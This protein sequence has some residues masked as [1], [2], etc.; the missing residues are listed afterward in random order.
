MIGGSAV[1]VLLIVAAGWAGW[2]AYELR[3]ELTEANSA[4][5][6]LRAAV[7]AGDDPAIQRA[8]D[9]LRE[10]GE[11]ASEISGGITWSALAHVPVYGDDARGIKV[12]SDVLADLTGDDLEPLIAASERI[13]T[14]LP[15]GGRV[16]ID[17]IVELQGPLADGHDALSRAYDDL[18]AQ[19]SSGFSGALRV[20]YDE[21]TAEI[22]R[23][24][25]ALAA[26]DTA[27]QVLPDMLG[28]TVDKRYLLVFQNN[29]EARS[30]GGLPGAVALLAASDGRLSLGRQVAGQ[31]FGTIRTPVLPLTAAET[32]IYGRL[33]GTD[34]RDAN[35][36]PDFPRAA[37]LWQARWEQVYDG[38]PVDGVLAVDPVA[39]SYL[40]GATGPVTVGGVT[41]TAENAVEELLSKTYARFPDPDDQDAWFR[42]VASAVFTAVTAGGGSGSDL[43]RALARGGSESRILVHSFDDVDQEE[44]AGT[45]I[46]G[47]L[48]DADGTA[49]QLGLYLNDFTQSKMSYY[50]DYDVDVSSTGCQDGVE[51]LT[52]SATFAST[53][54]ARG[55][56]LTDYV[57]GGY[58]GLGLLR[59]SQVVAVRL[60]GPLG[61][62]ITGL[63]GDGA[64]VDDF[65]V[66]QQD[67]RPVV[68]TFLP[69][70]PGEQAS[71]E[72]QVE[73]GSGQRG[74]PQVRLTPGARS[75][76]DVVSIGPASC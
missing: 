59:G 50:L 69:L 29:A 23:A 34:F 71:I 73:A 61:G 3:G 2:R 72:W 75:G 58:D 36:T 54:P 65:E 14:L 45:R 26:A 74:A 44:L 20:K 16:P 19:S 64:S 6:E 13:D 68:T 66:V 40:L 37:A 53:A 12:A 39:L 48:S 24:E 7:D 38:E 42:Q 32:Q 47:E 9:R 33:L 27:A 67:G 56:G 22:G 8:V 25:R 76:D 15:V 49:P 63:A 30:T 28:G 17:A 60:Y 51:Q 70:G 52:V 18:V 10:H 31:S 55:A 11:R 1:A 62:D 35:F 46:A 57:T 21:L 5:G 41:L 43:L 4:L